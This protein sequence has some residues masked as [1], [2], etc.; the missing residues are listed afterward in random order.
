MILMLNDGE[1][2]VIVKNGGVMMVNGNIMV[3]YHG[4]SVMV[5]D[6]NHRYSIPAESFQKPKIK[7]AFK[8]K[9]DLKSLHHTAVLKTYSALTFHFSVWTRLFIY[10]WFAIKLLSLALLCFHLLSNCL[11]LLSSCFHVLSTCSHSQ[12]ICFCLLCFVFTVVLPFSCASGLL[13]VVSYLKTSALNKLHL[14]KTISVIE[15]KSFK[16]DLETLPY[17]ELPHKTDQHFV[18]LPHKL[19][20]TYL[21]KDGKSLHIF[22]YMCIHFTLNDTLLHSLGCT[23]SCN[24]LHFMNLTEASSSAPHD[25][26]ACWLGCPVALARLGQG[27][28]KDHC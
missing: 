6:W 26:Q 9:A 15:F 14:L 12:I 27:M 10:F 17:W 8:M 22:I 13:L 20:Y 16:Q 4:Y 11:H 21:H 28:G 18:Y 25:A 5:S 7:M 3:V 24:Q 1:S 2:W 19:Y 23:T